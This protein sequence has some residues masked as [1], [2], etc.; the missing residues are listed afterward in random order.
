MAWS[1]STS[2]AERFVKDGDV[3]RF[4]IVDTE[5]IYKGDMVRVNANGEA[6]S[7]STPAEGDMF[8][9]V[10][11][12]TVDNTADGEYI[13][14]DTTG[15]F[16]FTKDTPAQSDVGCIAYVDPTGNQGTVVVAAGTGAGS[17]I[18]V[19]G[20]IGLDPNDSTKLRV[21]LTPMLSLGAAAG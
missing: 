8:V 2:I 18:V 19:G 7:T 20:V 3:L 14:V 6:T 13:T 10:A 9:G 11:R 1:A 12:E 21:K 5:T 4:P 17:G 16:S 15:V